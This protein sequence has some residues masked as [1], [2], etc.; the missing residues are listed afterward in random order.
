LDTAIDSALDAVWHY[1]WLATGL[2]QVA[3]RRR[4]WEADPRPVLFDYQV[5]FETDGDIRRDRTL[6]ARPQPTPGTPRHP[7]YGS[8]HSTY[9]AAASYVLACL[10]PNYQ[11]EFVKLAENI[12]VARIWGGVHWRTDHTFGQQIGVTVGKLVIQQ[13]NRSGISPA[14]SQH[15]DPPDR[16]RLEREAQ[17]F[18]RNCG[19][20]TSNFCATRLDEKIIQGA[21]G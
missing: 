5:R 14:P 9:S 17:A 1:K 8:G 21:Q 18:E 19:R 2:T 20:G 7:A 15:V 16:V 11:R 12:G 3:R 10:L 4:P 13:L 6:K